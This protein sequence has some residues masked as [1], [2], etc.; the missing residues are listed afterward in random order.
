ME[1]KAILAK[2][3]RNLQETKLLLNDLNF[4]L[5]NAPENKKELLTSWITT[6]ENMY[7]L[8]LVTLIRCEERD[9][10]LNRRA[11]KIHEKNCHIKE[12]KGQI[13]IIEQVEKWDG[14]LSKMP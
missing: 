11:I 9:K 5:S 13:K 3:N 8:T 10:E 4:K 7:N 14:K 1:A 2:G 12:L 6:I